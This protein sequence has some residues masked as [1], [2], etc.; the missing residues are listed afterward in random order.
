MWRKASTIIVILLV[1]I[2]GLAYLWSGDERAAQKAHLVPVIN[3]VAAEG[4]IA[5]RPDQRA[6][7]SAEVSGRIEQILVDNLSPVKKEQ[8]LTALYNADLGKRIAETQ[9]LYR[10]AEASYEQLTNGSRKEDIR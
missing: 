8:L 10:K 3:Y 1:L 4:H 2:F 6:V 9:A 5:V 7:L